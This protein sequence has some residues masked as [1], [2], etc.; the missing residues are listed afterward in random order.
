VNPL[1]HILC[2]GLAGP[3]DAVVRLDRRPGGNLYLDENQLL[4]PLMAPPTAALRDL[5]DIAAYVY[6]GDQ[7]V[8]RG[9]QRTRDGDHGWRR[10]LHFRIPVRCPDL[11]AARADE[12]ADL[13]GFLSDDD[14]QFTFAPL[15][16]P[17][18]QTRAKF[19]RTPYQEFDEVALFSG[20]LDSLAGAVQLVAD[21]KQPLLVTHRPIA[22]L[23]GRQARLL[24]GLRERAG[25]R[26]PV[27]L[28]VRVN[29]DSSLTRDNTQ[30]SRSFL[31]AALGGLIAATAGKDRLLVFENG[32]L[33]LN[34][35]P[36]GAVVGGRATRTTHP[37]VLAGLSRLLTVVTDRPFVVENPFRDLTETEVVQ[38]L[39]AAG[40]RDLIRWSTSCVHTHEM[41]S[42][43]PHCGRCSQCIDR[44]FAVLAAGAGADDPAECYRV[45]L[46]AGDRDAESAGLLA[47]YVAQAAEVARMTHSVQFFARYGEAVRAL[48]DG[49][50][51]MERVA[52]RVFRLYGRH[53][54]QVVGVVDQA[55]AAHPTAIRERTLPPGS[56]VRLV[57]GEPPEVPTAPEPETL[58]AENVFR[59]RGQGWRVR[60]GGGDEFVLLRQKGADHLHRLLAR[61][62]VPL[63]ADDGTPTGESEQ[64]E[65]DRAALV[66]CK[67]R[68]DELDE[69]IENGRAEGDTVRVEIAIKEK[70]ELLARLKADTRL[71]GK[72]R[73]M[74]GQS[75]KKRKA[76]GNALKRV[77]DLIAEFDSVLAAHLAEHLTIGSDPVFSPPA[78]V[79]WR[80][81]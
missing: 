79:V 49:T 33:S 74:G 38:S 60:Y 41:S 11:W 26:R 47:G 3:T 28:T 68:V 16:D 66:A 63:D 65:T 76:V 50:E 36:N 30:R 57:C 17:A 7:A 59:L 64:T 72:L 48:A 27:H 46:V 5:L 34:L 56:L 52:D 61:P 12:L 31:Y 81:D 2:G 75:E 21:G 80:T 78:G 54:R 20:G 58:H 40:G 18:G 69:E 67:K 9:G 15:T 6:A 43:F 70:E 45:D 51:P 8:E 35:P 62:T 14:Y 4:G 77:L 44:R 53:G 39:V 55:I 23:A 10:A 42:E 1:T 22:K 13:L 32:T 73:K 29:K 19:G 24:D 37:R 71:G 25:D